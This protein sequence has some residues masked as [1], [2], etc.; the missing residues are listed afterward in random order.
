MECNPNGDKGVAIITGS[1]SGIGLDLAEHLHSQGYHF[2]L[3]GRRVELGEAVASKLDPTGATSIVFIANAGTL[4]SASLYNFGWRSESIDSLPPVPHLSCME[5]N[6]K[7]TLYGT[8]LAT[9]FM[10]HNPNPGG[11]IIITS[12][13][14]G[15]YPCPTFPEYSST[16]AASVAFAHATSPVLLQKENITINVVL[17]GAYDTTIVPGFQEAFLPKHLAMKFCILAAYDVFLKD[18]SNQ[19]TGQCVE[20]AHDKL[21]YHNTPAYKSGEIAKRGDAIYEPW[22]TKLH[23]EPSEVEGALTAPP[24]RQTGELY[25]RRAGDPKP[26]DD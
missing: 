18:D 26:C 20:T 8:T 24:N 6:Y 4:D 12:S 3:A 9:H 1:T 19:I 21:Y 17:P 25:E 2:G 16:K 10:R 23:G 5:V 13:L 14:F 7:G 22:F 15:I 11:K